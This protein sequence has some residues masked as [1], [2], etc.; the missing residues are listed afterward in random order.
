MLI[1]ELSKDIYKCT[2]REN[3]NQKQLFQ[4]QDANHFVKVFFL[5]VLQKLL[6]N[7]SKYCF[8]LVQ[9]FCN[10]QNHTSIL[11][12]MKNPLPPLDASIYL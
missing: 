8:P 3:N 4:V 6:P 5:N 1:V 9:N 12:H 2:N 11:D 10:F 7:V